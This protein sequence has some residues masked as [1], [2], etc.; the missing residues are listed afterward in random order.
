M[1]SE[2]R[3][4]HFVSVSNPSTS[5]ISRQG[6][7]FVTGNVRAGSSWST[8]SAKPQDKRRAKRTSRSTTVVPLKNQA[9]PS[10][11]DQDDPS[12]HIKI[13][14]RQPPEVLVDFW[15][16]RSLH[17]ISLRQ[18]GVSIPGVNDE[19]IHAFLTYC[20]YHLFLSPTRAPRHN[21][22]KCNAKSCH[23]S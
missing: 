14:K 7:S 9:L 13:G 8:K 18:P 20:S 16:A 19:D 3:S 2:P 5:T 6:R 21:N 22:H 12:Q 17:T 11:T 15:A 23:R 4:F 1:A 10:Q